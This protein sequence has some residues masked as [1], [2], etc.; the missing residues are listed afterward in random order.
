MRYKQIGGL[1][2][3]FVLSCITPKAYAFGFDDLEKVEAAEQTELLE[4]AKQAARN[5]NFSKAESFIKQTQHKG[6]APA[7]L[8]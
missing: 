3:I 8:N 1:L 2:G 4:L 6:Y 5:N 7:Q